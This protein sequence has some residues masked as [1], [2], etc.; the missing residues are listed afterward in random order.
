MLALCALP[1]AVA[2]MRQGHADGIDPVFIGMWFGGEVLLFAYVAL[3][4]KREGYPP[5]YPL[6][7]NYGLNIALTGVIVG[8]MYV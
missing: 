1:Q 6:L 5:D 3:K 2:V 8:Y 7:I 4:G